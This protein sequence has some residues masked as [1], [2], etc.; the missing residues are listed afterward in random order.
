MDFID[1]T[2]GKDDDGRRLDKIARKFLSTQGLSSLYKSIRSGLIKLN[3]RKTKAEIRVKE[4]DVLSV[5]DFLTGTPAENI[6]DVNAGKI[7]LSEITVFKN[8]HILILNK[9]YDIPVQ[10]ASKGQFS[11][12]EAVKADYLSQKH[13]HSLSFMPGPM[14]RLDRKTTGLIAFSQ[15][16]E[17]ARYFSEAIKKHI[18]RK[19]YVAPVTGNMVSPEEWTDC[20]MKNEEDSKAF[21]TVKA[22]TEGKTALT[23]ALPLAHGKYNGTDITLVQFTIMTGRTHQIRSQSSLHGYP[24]AGDTAYSAIPLRGGKFFL[25]A[26]RL[27]LPGDNSLGLPHEITCPPGE[28]FKEFLSVALINWDGGLII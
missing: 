12:D 16:L 6:S 11:L 27:I 9:P 1:F 26:V 7:N 25:H 15:S 22:G 18:I 2:A 3:G 21:R 5:A 19:I 23:R 14:H 10:K 24:L 8:E 4:G 17:G 20:I 13:P 28:D